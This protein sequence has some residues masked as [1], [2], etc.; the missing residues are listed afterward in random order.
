MDSTF[1]EILKNLTIET[2]DMVKTSSP[3]V[4]EM[5]RQRV[6]AVATTGLWIGI[7]GLIL[8]FLLFPIGIYAIKKHEREVGL[9][10]FI[11]GVLMLVAFGIVLGVNY[12]NLLSIDYLT[13][14][15]IIETIKP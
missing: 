13:A 6:I 11:F 7:A 10:S 5:F 3:I 4:W 1:V 8:G 2:I 9:W 14:I 15:K 12:I